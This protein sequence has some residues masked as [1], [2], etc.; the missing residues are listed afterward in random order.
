M[1]GGVLAT[2]GELIVARRPGFSLEQPFYTSE[3]VFQ[4]DLK[5]VFFRHWLFAGHASRMSK[6]GDY[7]TLELGN[8][9]IIIIRDDELQLHALWNVCRHRGS[10]ICTE[11][12]GAAKNLVCPYHQ[13]VYRPDGTLLKARLMPEGFETAGY[14]LSRAH[15]RV[16]EGLI[17][18]SAADAPPDFERL[19]ERIEVRL[20]PHDLSRAKVCHRKR[21]EIA[22]NWKLVVENSRECYHCGVGH[23]QY[24][25]AV[26]FAA[27]LGSATLQAEHAAIETERKREVRELGLETEEIPFFPDSWYHYRRFF[28]R[29]GFVTESMD[30]QPVAPLMGNLP[31]RNTGVFAVVTLPNL[32][33]EASRDYVMTL[34][35][36][37]KGPLLTE[38][39]VCW[40]VRADAREGLDYDVDRLTEFWRLTSEQ[41]WELCEDNQKGV[42]SSKYAPG[43][44]GPAESGVEHFL[45]WYVKQL[46][47]EKSPLEPC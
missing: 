38:A 23:P 9:S 32:L 42:N 31:D 1:R 35:L 22:A 36:T 34:R 28:L 37:P 14:G 11:S 21:Y 20:R 44:Y 15:V 47:P 17:F 33:L 19:R 6:P 29:S 18:V 2:L 26:G 39:E 10:R 4:E 16:M 13:W 3:S 45:R 41:D 30:G 40:L 27:A 7:F 46:V 25:R 24:C 12:E 8:E 43:A 5:R